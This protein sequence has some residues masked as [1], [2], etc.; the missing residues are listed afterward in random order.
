MRLVILLILVNLQI[1]T[2]SVLFRI[3]SNNRNVFINSSY[4]FGTLHVAQNLIWP[5][6]S[7]E[8]IGILTESD[9]IWLEHDFTVD[10]TNKHIY[11]CA[12]DK[13]P[14]EIRA[15]IRKQTW[16]EFL[17]ETNMKSNNLTQWRQWFIKKQSI[18]NKYLW[19]NQT[20]TDNILL[21]HRIILEGYYRG[22]YV[23]SLE[24]I[25]KNCFQTESST[26][27][28][29]L[30]KKLKL[31]YQTTLSHVYNCDKINEDFL[32]KICSCIDTLK[33][34]E[35]NEQMTKQIH[36]LL[37]EN[38]HKKYLFAVGAAHLFGNISIVQ[39]LQEQYNNDYLIEQ[40]NTSSPN[41]SYQ[42]CTDNEIYRSI[43]TL[44]GVQNN[45]IDKRFINDEFLNQ[46]LGLFEYELPNRTITICPSYSL[47]SLECPQIGSSLDHHSWKTT[48]PNYLIS[49]DYIRSFPLRLGYDTRSC[50]PDLAHAC[51]NYDLRYINT[52]CN[53]KPQCTDISA[54]QIRERSLCAFK[55]V[56]EIGFHCVPTWNLHE[57]ETKCDICKNTSLTTNYGFIYSRNYPLKTVRMSCFTTIYARPNQK[58][59]LYFVNGELNHDQ[60]RIESVTSDGLSILNISLN[61]N[62]TTQRLAA[63]I[64]EMKITFI[65]SH[66]YSYH[67]T[68]YLLYFY[69][70]PICSITDP[71]LPLPSILPTTPPI[72]LPISTNRMRI[73]SVGWTRVPNIWII[74]P[75]IL[76]YVLLL[77]LIVV[78]ALLLQRR[79]KQ[80]KLS[81]TIGQPNIS[82]RYLDTSGA[83]SRVQLVTPLPPPNSNKIIHDSYLSRR[84]PSLSPST[85]HSQPPSSFAQNTERYHR[86]SR[87]DH[88]LHNDNIDRIDYRHHASI[89]YRIR[90]TTINDNYRGYGTMDHAPYKSERNYHRRSI[91]KSFSDC[92]LCKRRVINEEYQQYLNEYDDNWRL[93]NTVER[94]VEPRPYRDK[95]KERVRERLT[96]RQISDGDVL[97]STTTVE[98]S[99]ILPRHQRITSESNRSNGP[100]HHLPFEYIPNDIRTPEFKRNTSQERLAT[101][102][103]HPRMFNNESGTTIFTTKFYENDDNDTIHRINKRLREPREIQEMSLRMNEQQNMNKNQY[104]HQPRC[105]N[106]NTSDI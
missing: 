28:K 62:L 74:I 58:I 8:T 5:Y 95:I 78:L 79:R 50:Q 103:N 77:L 55:A 69:T 61:G 46:I 97:P 44:N 9:Q 80:Q 90:P 59:I 36:K 101:E 63:S 106:E 89:P 38:S 16:S 12:V 1:C 75:I 31:K 68:Y 24:S 87:S 17:D 85:H 98:Y 14:L 66:I 84:R 43:N 96:V 57:I 22:K 94:K 30:S 39:M 37:K 21:D 26:N 104:Y 60:L 67:P 25:P 49:I 19:R 27:G 6:L 18:L 56:T 52:L 102:N 11:G 29:R 86:E 2:S 32:E 40:I 4:L 13:M 33:M 76:A 73:Q 92:D 20:I 15:R 82:P 81:G 10:E 42:Y 83:S 88:D 45:T 64:Y 48:L 54:Y 99:T 3:K 41:F 71:C 23:G 91:P 93:K 105:F 70:I 35:R 51:N 7:N 53:G 100:V 65:P 47:I 72:L 34:R